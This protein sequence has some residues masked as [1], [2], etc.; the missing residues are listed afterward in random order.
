MNRIGTRE[1]RGGEKRVDVEITLL[2][3]GRSDA[4][5]FI[6]LLH[7]QRAGVGIAEHRD[8]AVAQPFG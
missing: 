2:R 1:F 8:G 7:V 5:G 6:R 3:R 4:D